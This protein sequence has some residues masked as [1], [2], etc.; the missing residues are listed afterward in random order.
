MLSARLNVFFASSI[1][2]TS[3]FMTTSFDRSRYRV[4][5]QSYLFCFRVFVTKRLTRT[6]SFF[7]SSL[8]KTCLNDNVPPDIT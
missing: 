5:S 2:C 8:N 4:Y 1:T 7:E 6:R 3:L